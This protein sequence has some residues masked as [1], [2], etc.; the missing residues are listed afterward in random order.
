MFKSTKPDFDS[1]S[2]SRIKTGTRNLTSY[3]NLISDLRCSFNDKD[4]ILVSDKDQ[5]LV[6]D[7]NRISVSDQNKNLVTLNTS[8]SCN[9]YILFSQLMVDI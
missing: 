5:K 8:C 1:L 2:R 7:H 3:N 6:S 9:Y 4:Q